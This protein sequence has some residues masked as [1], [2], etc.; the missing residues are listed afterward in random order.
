MFGMCCL[1]DANFNRN[2]MVDKI[3]Q[4]NKWLRRQG[5]KEAEKMQK[6]AEKKAIYE[7]EQAEAQ[8]KAEEGKQVTKGSGSKAEAQKAAAMESDQLATVTDEPS[9]G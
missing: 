8:K 4:H 2:R 3:Y 5:E 7:K 9:A 1:N 6:A